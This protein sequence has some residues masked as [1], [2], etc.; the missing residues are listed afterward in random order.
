MSASLYWP[1][2]PK[3][4]GKS[5]QQLLAQLAPDQL[6]AQGNPD[7]VG[8]TVIPPVV[9]GI[10]DLEELKTSNVIELKVSQS[11]T[12][13]LR[14][15]IVRVSISDPSIAEPILVAENQIVFL[16]HTSGGATLVLWDDAGN[17]AAIDLRVS[18][19]FSQLQAALR[20]IDPRIIIKPINNGEHD[21]IIL[22]GDV[23]HPES[24]IRAFGSANVFMADSG[25]NIEVANSRLIKSRVGE[26]GAQGG[27]GGGGGPNW[28]SCPII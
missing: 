14:N 21:R 24:I 7:Y 22:L 11:R 8:A 10:V 2:K 4:S 6:M 28:S 25:M 15:K 3:R 23:D 17:S 18:R 1:V 27:G 16:G 26:Q 12:F 13:K 19:D 20:E 9:T 5:S